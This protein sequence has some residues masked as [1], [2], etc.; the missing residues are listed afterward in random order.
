MAHNAEG[1]IVPALERFT[2]RAQALQN[3]YLS[4]VRAT[5]VIDLGC[6]EVC[7][8]RC[9]NGYLYTFYDLSS[10][11]SQ[12]YCAGIEDALTLD[13]GVYSLPQMTLYAK[14]SPAAMKSFYK[15]KSKF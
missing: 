13:N 15:L 10:C 9:T 12:C 7:V 4:T 2:A 6:D 11:I 3:E 1:I 14:G 8:N 5:A